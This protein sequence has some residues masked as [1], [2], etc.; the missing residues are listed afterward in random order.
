H[1]SALA[2]DSQRNSVSASAAR[3]VSATSTGVSK[4]IGPAEEKLTIDQLLDSLVTHLETRGAKTV[5]RLK[6][7]LKPLP[8]FFV[9]DKAVNVRTPDIERYVA[10]R[11]KA[12][13]ARATVNR[14]TGALKQAFN[15]ARKQGVLSKVP[16]IAMLR[17]DNAR[18]GFFEHSDFE[19][20]VSKLSDP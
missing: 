5:K 13:K 14:E 19:K 12:K 18:Q 6:S 15:L 17:E 1:I 11:L 3:I 7:H 9:L 4:S 2:Q 8:K 16:Y 10:E 20:F